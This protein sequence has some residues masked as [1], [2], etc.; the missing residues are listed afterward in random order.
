MEK[1]QQLSEH[2]KNKSAE[3]QVFTVPLSESTQIL[4]TIST[5]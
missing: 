4:A 1:L 3:G 2:L 5:N